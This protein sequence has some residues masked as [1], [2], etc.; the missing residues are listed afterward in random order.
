M[1]LTTDIFNIIF[2]RSVTHVQIYT[3]IKRLDIK[4]L[5]IKRLDIKR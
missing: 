1:P 3:N 2:N 4:R 5:D